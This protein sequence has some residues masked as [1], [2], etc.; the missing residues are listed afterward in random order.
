MKI[1][2]RC[3]WTFFL[4]RRVFI[5]FLYLH[6]IKTYEGAQVEA[7]DSRFVVKKFII[8]LLMLL[9]FTNVQGNAMD[10]MKTFNINDYIIISREYFLYDLVQ[11]STDYKNTFL[12]LEQIHKCQVLSNLWMG[13]ELDFPFS[14]V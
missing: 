8:P 12:K 2:W 14:N 10:K 4:K 9:Y 5:Q 11:S 13:V 3:E 1:K 6:G 7:C